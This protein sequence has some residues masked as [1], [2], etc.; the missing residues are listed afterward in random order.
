MYSRLHSLILVC[1]LVWLPGTA[2]AAGGKKDDKKGDQQAAATGT[3][4]PAK[5]NKS[6]SPPC[7]CEETEDEGQRARRKA[8][9]TAP[10]DKAAAVE[11]GSGGSGRAGR[12]EGVAVA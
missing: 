6:E 2:L 10:Q 12:Q 11:H 7:R 9:R 1:G 8:Y 5:R 3:R 4:S